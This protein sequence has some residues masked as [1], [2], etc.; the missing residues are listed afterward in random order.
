MS[1]TEEN[2]E[3]F[4]AGECYLVAED[5]THCYPVKTS[6]NRANKLSLED[7]WKLREVNHSY[8]DKTI[9]VIAPGPVTAVHEK[10][11]GARRL[12][13]YALTDPEL[14]STKMP[15]ELPVGAW[16][17]EEN[18]WGETT[19]PRFSFYE[20]VWSQ[21]PD[22]LVAHSTADLKKLSGGVDTRTDVEWAC[23]QPG[24]LVYSANYRHLLPGRIPNAAQYVVAALKEEFGEYDFWR[25]K[26]GVN[27][28]THPKPGEPKH[29]VELYVSYSPP[30]SETRSKIGSRGQKLKS[31]YRQEV[32][33]RVEIPV[34]I[35]F[36]DLVATSKAASNLHT[37]QPYA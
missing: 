22:S 29:K 20:K 15:L 33:K 21:E 24:A 6:F 11:P 2:E 7:G 18:D 10:I 26:S 36:T 25:D 34:K 27:T 23:D 13:K 17:G 4:F 35:G 32:F 5:G 30:V 37:A 8:S 3:E 31:T 9:W 19:D 28:T 1:N 16:E 12:E 14:E